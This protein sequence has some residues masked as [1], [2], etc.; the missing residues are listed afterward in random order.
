MITCS[1]PYGNGG[2]EDGEPHT[3]LVWWCSVLDPRRNVDLCCVIYF[4]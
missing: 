3:T 1:R 4:T 2:V